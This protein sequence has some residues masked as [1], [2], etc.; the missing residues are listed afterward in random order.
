MFSVTDF[1]DRKC[2]KVVRQALRKNPNG[3]VVMIGCYAQLKPR[4]IA[5]IPGV[6]LVLGA[7]EKF[8]LLDYIEDLSKL[9][10]KGLIRAGE[11]Q[12]AKDFVN[13][14]SLASPDRIC[15]SNVWISAL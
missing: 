4:E 5:D 14:F 11:V 10:G 8:R 12:E 1:A 7:A 2:R 9:P 15:G 13:A 3:F 6:D